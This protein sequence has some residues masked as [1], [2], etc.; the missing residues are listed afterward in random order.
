MKVI[1]LADVRGTGRRFEVKN[2]SD[3]YA[4]NFLFP[5]KL[6][7]QATP[8]KIK[9]IEQR[10]KAHAEEMK[11]QNELLKKNLGILKEV[12]IEIKGKANEKEHLFK[13]IDAPMIVEALTKQAHLTLPADAV[14]LPKPIKEVG[15]FVIEVALAG[16]TSSFTLKVSAL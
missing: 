2:V 6:A 5:N 7:E 16:K 3:G 15:E 11:I 9:E 4:M 14:V 13:G 8:Q 12:T 10:Q 1:L